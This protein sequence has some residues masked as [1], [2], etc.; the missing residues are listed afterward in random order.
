MNSLL[1]EEEINQEQMA[2]LYLIIKNKK[3]DAE[4]MIIDCLLNLKT[5]S[6]L[7]FNNLKNLNHLGYIETS[8]FS[9]FLF[10]LGMES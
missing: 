5:S 4:T 9:L 7:K 8:N 2:K 6:V 10:L 1:G 3:L